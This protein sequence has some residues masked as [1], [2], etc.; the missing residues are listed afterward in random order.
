M[1]ATKFGPAG[2]DYQY[3]A[4]L[5]IILF[6]SNEQRVEEIYIDKLDSEDLM[7]SIIDNVSGKK[8]IVEFEFKNRISG[9]DKDYFIKCITKFTASRDDEYILSK[10]EKGQT[11]R[12]Y[13]FTSARAGQY[14]E[15]Y[16]VIAN[17]TTLLK[18]SGKRTKKIIREFRDSI[19]GKKR[20]GNARDNFVVDHLNSLSDDQVESL[21]QSLIIV[22]QFNEE[23]LFQRIA[24]LLSLRGIVPSAHDIIIQKLIEII[25]NSRVSG[26]NIVELINKLLE[27]SR[28]R[29]PMLNSFYLNVGDEDA[30]LNELQQNKMLLLT[31]T[32]LC[33]K[34]QRAYRLIEMLLAKWPSINYQPAMDIR[35]AEQFLFDNATEGRICY[36]EDPL[37]QNIGD[38]GKSFYKQLESL[39]RNLPINRER[40]LICTSTSEI[41]N[42][43]QE[44]SYLN[45]FHW[46][47]LTVK[48]K[49]FLQ[50][51]WVKLIETYA[52]DFPKN[53]KVIKQAIDVLQ[54]KDILQPGQLS[55]LARNFEERELRTIEEVKHVA[56]FRAQDITEI[57]M[58]KGNTA[59]QLMQILGIGDRKSVV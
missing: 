49:G 43:L 33:G 8:D 55:Y 10:L 31:G 46:N 15:D 51:M 32:T 38:V 39:V 56:N 35:T 4:S 1:Q 52:N 12:F 30:L 25:K 50:A 41:V 18:P 59:V 28:T 45:N 48:D 14:S 19:I 22:D 37:G 47:D 40:Y 21:L 5:F 9:F 11:Q 34:T 16:L 29:P 7:L 36:L 54:G 26:N 42:A 3:L 24:D 53:G 58:A 27:A 23:Y 17:K 20:S 2:Y 44:S 57:I 13:L 6:F